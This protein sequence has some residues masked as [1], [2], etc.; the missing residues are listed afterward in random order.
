VQMFY[1]ISG[2]YMALV[3]HRRYTARGAIAVS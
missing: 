2:F 1:V 3:L